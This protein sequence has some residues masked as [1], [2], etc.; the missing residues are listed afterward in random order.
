MTSILV[1]RDQFNVT[2]QGVIH[3][4]TGAS[5]TPGLGD[6]RSGTIRLGQLGNVLPTGDVYD[7]EEVK[8]I[9]RELWAD[10]VAAGGTAKSS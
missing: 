6:S 4:P 8:R 10:Y 1:R 5:L 7:T 3:K 9:M 2:P